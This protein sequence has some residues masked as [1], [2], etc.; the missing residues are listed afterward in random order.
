[1]LNVFTTKY[2]LTKY[3][4]GAE[5]KLFRYSFIILICGFAVFAA[6]CQKTTVSVVNTSS[7]ILIRSSDYIAKP[8]AKTEVNGRLIKMGNDSSNSNYGPSFDFDK[9][10]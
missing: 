3:K 6:G 10:N 9:L 4:A 8:K 5:M 2:V 7:G 1:M